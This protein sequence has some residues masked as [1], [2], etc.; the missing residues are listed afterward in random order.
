MMEYEYGAELL[1][2]SRLQQW[3]FTYS[4]S[5]I[6]KLILDFMLTKQETL[7]VL[8]EIATKSINC[9]LEDG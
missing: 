3:P 1:H 5:N 8:S 2:L 7:K 6:L 4:I 9:S